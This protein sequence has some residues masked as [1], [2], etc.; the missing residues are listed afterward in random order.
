MQV[1]LVSEKC[2][3]YTPRNVELLAYHQHQDPAS[4][5]AQTNN[6]AVVLELARQ[7]LHVGGDPTDA[8]YSG[9]FHPGDI[10][11]TDAVGN[12]CDSADCIFSNDL[13]VNDASESEIYEYVAKCA[14]TGKSNSL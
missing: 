7:I 1:G 5:E 11:S 13:L 4:P 9:T 3:S 14:E 2:T 6:K 12:S 8:L 10:T